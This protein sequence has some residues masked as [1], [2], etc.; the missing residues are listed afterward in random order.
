MIEQVIA[1]LPLNTAVYFYRTNA[2]AEID[3]LFF[4][5][6]NRPVAIEVKYSLSPAVS[7][8]FWSVYN[9][10]SCQ[11]GYVI[12]PGSEMYPLSKGVFALPIGELQRIIE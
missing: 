5:R 1:L 3:L 8:G 12:Y 7:R 10:L 6:K 2:G 11:K 4:D 9:D